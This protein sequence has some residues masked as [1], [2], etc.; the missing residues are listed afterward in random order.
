M[1]YG[2]SPR[3]CSG[4]CSG[5]QSFRFNHGKIS[6]Q[7]QPLECPFHRLRGW[8]DISLRHH[9]AAMPCNPHDGERVH[10]RFPEPCKHCMAW[11]VE[12]KIPREER[13]TLAATPGASGALRSCMKGSPSSPSHL[14]DKQPEI[15]VRR[16]KTM[17]NQAGIQ[18]SGTKSSKSNIW[19]EFRPLDRDPRH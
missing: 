13:L 9:D 6:G 4:C 1:I 16:A 15:T 14:C 5:R 2:R 7:L 8:M 17:T 19:P 12:D 18:F 10:S 3:N 11:G